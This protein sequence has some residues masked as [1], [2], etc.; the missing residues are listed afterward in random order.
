MS[1]SGSSER[2]LVGRLKI[3][4]T[5]E[6]LRM[7]VAKGIFR[8]ADSG[9]MVTVFFANGKLA[10]VR[11]KRGQSMLGAVNLALEAF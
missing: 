5:L 8:E 6:E 1:R 2:T 3:T 4:K 11:K 10:Y 9:T 7:S